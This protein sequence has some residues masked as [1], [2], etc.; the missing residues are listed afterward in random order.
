MGLDMYL[1]AKKTFS[2]KYDT[3]E[4]QN[5]YKHLVNMMNA[6]NFEASKDELRFAD[7]RV[8]LAYWRK[9]NEIHN[10]FI[11]ECANG[12]DNCLP[13][14]VSRKNLSELLRRC[15]LILETKD[16]EIAKNTLP[17]TSGFCFG[18]TEY[19]DYYFQS[20]EH[21]KDVLETILNNPQDDWDFEYQ[22]SW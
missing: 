19:D 10:F 21:T 18:G 12:E 17:T 11:S 5:D 13:V 4:N 15:N 8:Q 3:P 6:S 1:Y 16:V 7:V 9:A 2:S 22:A 14:W 20:L